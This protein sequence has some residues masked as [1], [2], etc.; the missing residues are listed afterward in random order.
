[1]VG[2]YNLSNIIT[3]VN[4]SFYLYYYKT[5]TYMKFL[6]WEIFVEFMISTVAMIK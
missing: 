4:K 1:M 2:T 5:V 3:F 6:F